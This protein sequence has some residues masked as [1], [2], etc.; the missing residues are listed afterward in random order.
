MIRLF[1]KPFWQEVKSS[2][3]SEQELEEMENNIEKAYNQAYELKH[4]KKKKLFN[5]LF[6]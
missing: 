3:M 1:S 5:I 4:V 6:T 2:R